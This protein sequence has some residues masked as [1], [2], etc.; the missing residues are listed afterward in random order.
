MNTKQKATVMTWAVA[1]LLLGLFPPFMIISHHQGIAQQPYPIGHNFVFT[2]RKVLDEYNYYYLRVNGGCLVAYLCILSG[3]SAGALILATPRAL[4][5]HPT[6]QPPSAVDRGE[7][8]RRPDEGG[9]DVASFPP[10]RST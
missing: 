6:D 8:G 7:R 4:T 10:D 5:T 1:V 9:L 3:A 2:T